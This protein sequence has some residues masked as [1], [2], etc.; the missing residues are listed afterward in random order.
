M[1]KLV[2]SVRELRNHLR[3]L[4]CSSGIRKSVGFVPTM[5][6]LHEGHRELIRESKVQNDIT[7]VS[8]YVNPLQFGPHED[9]QKYPRN[10]ERDL[11]LCEEEGVDIVF[12]P[13]DE[14]MYP[15]S[16]KVSISIPGLTDV[17]EGKFR[18]KHFEGVAIVVLKLFSMVHPDRAY[19]GEKDYQQLK[20]VQRLVKDLSLPI[21]IVPVKTVRDKDGLA[22]SSRN[23]YLSEQERKSALSIYKSFLLA[24]KLYSGGNRD[25]QVIKEAVRDFIRKHPL[26]SKIDYIEIRDEELRPVDSVKDGDRLL[27]ALWVGNTRLIDNWRFKDEN[28]RR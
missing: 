28:I 7:V 18:P 12:A 2:K 8:I 25:P 27:I 5:G 22:C 23:V 19:F 15:E 24:Q 6:Y 1:P 17:L 16:P 13:T 21:E 26:V 20:V 3:S 14:E 10:L 9:Y 4:V 11:E